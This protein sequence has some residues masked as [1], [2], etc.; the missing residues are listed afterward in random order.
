[1]QD[2]PDRSWLD[3]RIEARAS[4]IHG[5]GLFATAPIA[6]GEV[7]ERWGG[8]VIDDAGLAA[9]VPPYSAAAIG[10][11]RH[12]VMGAD[13]PLRFGNHSCDPN[14]SM[15]SATSV[16][17]RRD[18]EPGEELTIDYAL[19]TVTASW[20][21]QCACGS[22]LCRGLVTGEDWRLP[23]LRARYRGRFSPFINERI[24]R[25]F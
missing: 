6:A 8:R 3:R 11:G 17:A 24:D 19:H 14:L 16:A 5:L 10:Q 25:A 23:D 18:I 4:A 1:V 20:S 2:I 15:D 21:M 12:L 9:I 13:D 7:V 22:L